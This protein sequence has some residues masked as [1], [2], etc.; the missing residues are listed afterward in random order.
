MF[1][2]ATN[3]P[4][5]EGE[6]LWASQAI[7][8]PALNDPRVYTPLSLANF[9][10]PYTRMD[11]LTPQPFHI[12]QTP[13]PDPERRLEVLGEPRLILSAER[14]TLEYT[15][16]L[17]PGFAFVHVGNMGTG[18]LPYYAVASVPWVTVLPYTGVAVGLN[19]PCDEGSP[20]DR[21]GHIGFLVWPR[22]IPPG[23]NEF[24]IVVQA[25]GTGESRV[26]Q[27]DLSP[28]TASRP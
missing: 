1:G 10:F 9:V 19:M 16:E 26:I 22:D 27:V 24:Q 18:V 17:S 5:V 2:C 13:A 4:V 23:I 12:D 15:N 14:L 20:C 8:L 6:R 21:F 28:F 11:L 7:T 3:P 25:L